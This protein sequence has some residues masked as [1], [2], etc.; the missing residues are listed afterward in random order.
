MTK[1]S[2]LGWFQE[3]KVEIWLEK[4]AVIMTVSSPW[5]CSQALFFVR[6]MNWVEVFTTT[7][8]RARHPRFRRYLC[9]SALASLTFMFDQHSLLIVYDNR[10][11]SRFPKYS[12]DYALWWCMWCCWCVF[13][14]EGVRRQYRTKMTFDVFIGHH[15]IRCIHHQIIRRSSWLHR[16]FLDAINSVPLMKPLLFI[17]EPVQKLMSSLLESRNWDEES[18]KSSFYTC[19]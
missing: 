16:F 17:H 3:F 10:R 1:I 19:I 2:P 14:S 18:R 7:P 8:W 4:D 13:L 6:D 15:R 12:L 9:L 11:E 5:C